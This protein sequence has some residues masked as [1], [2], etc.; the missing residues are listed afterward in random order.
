M[1]ADQLVARRLGRQWIF[2][3]AVFDEDTWQLIVDGERRRLE[4]KPLELLHELLLNAGNVVSKDQLLDAVWPNVNVVEASI[5]TGIGKLRKALCDEDAA[6]PIIETV[7]RIG[8][9]LACEVTCH[10]SKQQ[11][12][13]RPANQSSTPRKRWP[14]IAAV[15]AGVTTLATLTIGYQLSARPAQAQYSVADVNQ[16]LLR[17]DQPGIETMLRTGWDPNMPLDDQGNTALNQLLGMCEW[18]PGHNRNAMLLVARTLLAGGTD[19]ARKNYWG[20]TAYS[21]AK[22]PRYCGP[23][24][25]VTVMLRMTCFNGY[26]PTGTNCLADYK[27]SAAAHNGGRL[28]H[29]PATVR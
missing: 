10:S 5:T 26:K 22:A 13:P 21:I 18:N 23:D 16:A 27:N 24:H 1:V 3:N 6:Q 4:V 17:L 12:A 28:P 19:A 20:D 8:Y 14:L 7:P 25:P 15:A 9:R 29:D 2:A 11:A